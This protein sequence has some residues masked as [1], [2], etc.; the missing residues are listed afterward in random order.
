M[1]IGEYNH[2]IDSKGRV[3]LPAKF[4]DILGDCFYITKG[5]DGCLFVYTT[6]GWEKL[7]EKLSKLPLTNPNARRIVRYYTSGAME[8]VPDN[9]GRI[10][11]SQTLREFAGLEKE[12]VSI[13]CNDRAEI[14]SRKNGKNTIPTLL[15]KAC[16]RIWLNLDYK[17]LRK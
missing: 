14:W 10:T 7:Q 2:N 13:G 11:L 8:C 4:R 9:N 12:I 5:N 15:M 3:I 6:E 17:D 1:F 16:L